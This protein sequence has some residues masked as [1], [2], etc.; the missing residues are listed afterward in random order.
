MR[1]FLFLTLTAFGT[2]AVSFL[3]PGELPYATI[4]LLA[5][6]L[7]AGWVL[8]R[9]D[10]RGAGAL[11][12]YL[13]PDAWKEALLGLGLGLVVAAAVVLAMV[14]CGAIWWSP[15]TG[16]ALE[17][18]RGG[19][20]SLWLFS[21][22]AA[23]E[24]ALMRGYLFQSLAEALGGI[25]ALWI[26]SFL[27]GILHIGNP[28][29]SWIGLANI[30]V[31]GLFLGVVYLKTAS[32]WWATGAHLGWNWAHGFL[33]DL[34]V[35]GLDLIDTP[36]LEPTT[37]GPEWLS[38]GSFGPEGSILSTLILLGATVVLWKTSWLRPGDRAR[39]LR[40]LVLVGT[41]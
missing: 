37:R 29:S 6:S 14:V 16:S 1:I 25:W 2:S 8:L 27:F 11:G 40:P 20:A 28:N 30:L 35:S 15:D 3:V 22:P 12:F 31:A 36:L 41:V 18:V 32:L 4:P 26:T 13:A 7:L 5:G 9:L 23:A 19:A 34:P 21:I 39:E 38:G 17:Y 24:E 10:G 33:S